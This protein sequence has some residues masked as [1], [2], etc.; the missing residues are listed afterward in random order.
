MSLASYQ[1]A[2]PR[3]RWM[4]SRRFRRRVER[5]E[6]DFSIHPRLRS[7][8]ELSRQIVTHNFQSPLLLGVP[9]GY[10]IAQ[11]SST[12]GYAALGFVLF[13]PLRRFH[14]PL[15]S[16]ARFRPLFTTDRESKNHTQVSVPNF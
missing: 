6:R 15:P 16:W 8:N 1:A 12:T 10:A 7:K 5:V 4:H 9:V 2:L 11:V 13:T 14:R 3:D